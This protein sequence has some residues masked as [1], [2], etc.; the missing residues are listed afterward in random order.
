MD[1]NN[2]N[3]IFN[4]LNNQQST[5]EL[6]LQQQQQIQKQA[7][8]FKIQHNLLY[9]LQPKTQKLI[10]VIRP[11]E[12]DPVLFMFHNDPTAAHASREKMFDKMK[13]RYY[14]PQMFEDIKAYTASCD[15]CQRRGKAKQNEP[16][17]PIP[18]GEPFYQIGID[19]VGPLNPTKDGNQYII[20]AIYGLPNE[21]ARS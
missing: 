1:I 13:D 9:K 4:Y 2:Y 3:N 15:A 19:Y 7:K 5:S 6:P 8:N 14:W 20:V 18:V 21:V 12:M 17:H 11:F 16:L 10:R